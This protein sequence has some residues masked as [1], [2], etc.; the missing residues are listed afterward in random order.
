MFVQSANYR[1]KDAGRSS[2]R[3]QVTRKK[4]MPIFSRKSIEK[5]QTCHTDLQVLLWEVIKG[6]DC[7]VLQGHRGEAEQNKAFA[8][9]RSK[10]QWPNGKHNAVPSMA[11]DIS[12]YPVDWK[13][14]GRFILLGG[15]V[16]GVAAQLRRD[17]RMLYDLRWGGDWNMDFDMNA[18]KFRDLGHFELKG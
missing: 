1:Q 7:I 5:L 11:V 17:G 15:Y 13:D 16:L 10:L 8:D 2:K 12:P 3:S 9:G 4:P 14:S 6:F 18:E